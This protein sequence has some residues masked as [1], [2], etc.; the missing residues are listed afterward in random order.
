MKT[1]AAAPVAAAADTIRHEPIGPWGT[2][3]EHPADAAE[4]CGYCFLSPER[5]AQRAAAERVRSAERQA[6]F[7]SP[8][9]GMTEVEVSVS[10]T[11]G[12]VCI[13]AGVP[14][15]RPA[16]QSAAW[17]AASRAAMDEIEADNAQKIAGRFIAGCW[18]QGI[19][20]ESRSTYAVL[21]PGEMVRDLRVELAAVAA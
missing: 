4:R 16:G 20:G 1:S 14:V 10:G 11:S 21:L 18:E 13:V 6:R 5:V 12:L 8:P 9:P 3:H 15:Y 17:D 19:G 7:R 2:P